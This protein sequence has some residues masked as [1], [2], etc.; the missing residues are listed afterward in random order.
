MCKSCECL[1]VCTKG[2]AA[3]GCVGGGGRKAGK[4]AAPPVWCSGALWLLWGRRSASFAATCYMEP[5]LASIHKHLNFDTFPIAFF[6]EI[7]EIY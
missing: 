6:S 3:I 1:Y 7:E 2:R 5:A 4:E